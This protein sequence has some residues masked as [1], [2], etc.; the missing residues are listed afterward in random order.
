MFL[1]RVGSRSQSQSRFVYLNGALAAGSV[2]NRLTHRKHQY[3]GIQ[4]NPTPKR[5]SPLPP[6]EVANGV[7]CMPASRLTCQTCI[8]STRKS[9]CRR[10]RLER[11][12]DRS[13]WVSTR[14]RP[15][16]DHPCCSFPSQKL[17]QQDERVPRNIW[18]GFLKPLGG[19]TLS[20]LVVF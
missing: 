6:P 14:C 11:F 17:S 8:S 5:M 19:F 15:F 20:F 2:T 3:G 4:L 9:I 16:P 1:A 13:R 7:M 10:H 18:D 12:S